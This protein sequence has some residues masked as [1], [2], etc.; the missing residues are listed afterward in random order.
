M[1]LLF[2]LGTVWIMGILNGTFH[3]LESG[4]NSRVPNVAT[5]RI[6]FCN[7]LFCCCFVL[8]KCLR[9]PKH[10]IVVVYRTFHV[11]IFI[12]TDAAVWDPGG[13]LLSNY[14]LL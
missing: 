10:C 11:S 13:L 7:F 2:L 6:L 14:S 3:L 4:N 5:E 12:D 8:I 1:D 9:L